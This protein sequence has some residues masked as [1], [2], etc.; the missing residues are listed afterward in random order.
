MIQ[1]GENSKPE[2]KCSKKEKIKFIYQQTKL[3]SR[4]TL[5]NDTQLWDFMSSKFYA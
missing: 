4:M 2:D 5:G 1:L 3:E